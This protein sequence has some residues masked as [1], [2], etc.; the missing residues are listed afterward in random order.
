MYGLTMVRNEGYSYNNN[1]NDNLYL[2]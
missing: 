1:Y 2:F